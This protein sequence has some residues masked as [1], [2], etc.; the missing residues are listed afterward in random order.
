MS[1]E[2]AI[3]DMM[4]SMAKGNSNEVQTKFNSIMFDRASTAV[5]DYKQEL[6]KSV[7]KNDDLQSMG[8]ADGEE[9]ILEVDPAAQPEVVDTGD[10]N[11]DI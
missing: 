2:D 8:L 9:R 10:N 5:N 4:D 7:F 3:R 1:R 6:A 11:E